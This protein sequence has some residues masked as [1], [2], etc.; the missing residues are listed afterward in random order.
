MWQFKAIDEDEWGEETQYCNKCAEEHFLENGMSI[1]RMIED[2][3]YGPAMFMDSGDL[4]KAGWEKDPDYDCRLVRSFTNEWK[5]K[6]EEMKTNGCKVFVE[7]DR[8]AIG[9]LEGYITLWYKAPSTDIIDYELPSH[10]ATAIVNGDFSGL[11]EDEE[12]QLNEWLESEKPGACVAI[13]GEEYFSKSCDVVG[14][15]GNVLTY[16]FRVEKENA[17]G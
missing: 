3:N 6:L 13:E 14:Y 9:G 7:A 17:N 5:K 10:W 11:D 15:V 1:D 4:E 12:R 16:K 2:K 8:M